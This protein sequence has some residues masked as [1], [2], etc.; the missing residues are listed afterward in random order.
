[1]ALIPKKWIFVFRV[2]P[3][4]RVITYQTNCDR[5]YEVADRRSVSDV[6]GIWGPV[7]FTGCGLIQVFILTRQDVVKLIGE[8]PAHW[9]EKGQDE[10]ENLT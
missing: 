4:L 8:D 3:N 5:P 1:M 2:G 9:L 10:C 7:Q 6:T